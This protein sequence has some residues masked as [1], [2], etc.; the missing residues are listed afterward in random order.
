MREVFS[1]SLSHP[2]KY[3]Q[4]WRVLLQV[5]DS[6]SLTILLSLLQNATKSIEF[7]A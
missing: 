6:H 2:H 1:P 3:L 4:V 7:C 5:W